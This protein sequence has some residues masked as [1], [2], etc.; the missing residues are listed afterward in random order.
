[1]RPEDFLAVVPSE[2]ATVVVVALLGAIGVIWLLMTLGPKNL[3]DVKTLAEAT[4][5][6]P[7][8]NITLKGGGLLV[9]FVVVFVLIV[10][11][12]LAL[13]VVPGAP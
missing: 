8:F 7:G 12:Y 11:L 10:V 13:R 9:L 4:V 2:A 6:I 5:K 3:R 1:M